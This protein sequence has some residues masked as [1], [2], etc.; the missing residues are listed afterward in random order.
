MDFTENEVII[1]NYVIAPG[2][3]AGTYTD[4]I[5]FTL[6]QTAELGQHILRAK[7]NWS[8]DVPDD[9]CV[10][11]SYGETEDYSVV[12]VESALGLVDNT[13]QLKPILYPNPSDGIVSLDLRS[14]YNDVTIQLNDILGRQVMNRNYSEG[15]V[16]NLN[17]TEEPGVYFLS[18][19]A[20]N[21]KVVF[22]L[23]IN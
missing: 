18:V 6:P 12:I 23:I 9:P 10:E 17:I 20:E 15:K 3:G 8:G 11:T 1:N 13:F 14:N 19:Y 21:R 16:F 2:L 22:K 5:N 7:A 4:I